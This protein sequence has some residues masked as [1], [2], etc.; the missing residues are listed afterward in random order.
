MGKGVSK[1]GYQSC[2]AKRKEPRQ[3]RMAVSDAKIGALT[4]LTPIPVY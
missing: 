1:R 4:A 2:Q 3:K